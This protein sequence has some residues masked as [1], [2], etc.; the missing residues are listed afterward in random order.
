MLHLLLSIFLFSFNNIFWKKNLEKVNII[1]LVSYRA[2]FT[3][4]IAFA[5]ANH[6]NSFN[7]LTLS[8]LVKV[9]IG[10]IFGVIGLLCMLT[11]IK[12][13]SLHWLGVYNL[14]GIIFSSSYLDMQIK[15][16]V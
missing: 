2:F 14:I 12:K 6:F 7:L 11:V 1:F 15:I 8:Q 13:A 16:T 3:S 10:S 4:I 9:T 5:L